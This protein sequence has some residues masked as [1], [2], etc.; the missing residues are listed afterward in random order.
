MN[1]CILMGKIVTNPELRYTPDSQLEIA[2]MLVEFPGLGPNDPPATLKTVGFGNLAKEIQQQYHEGEQVI[3]HG[4]LRMNT[5]ERQE[6]FKEKRAELSI[7]HIYKLSATSSGSSFSNSVS[8][9]AN[10]NNVVPINR[11]SSYEDEVSYDGMPNGE[12]EGNLDDIPF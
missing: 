2:Q 12:N 4:R 10:N 8:G 7:S 1:T 9:A 6:G 11:N 5:F 3:V